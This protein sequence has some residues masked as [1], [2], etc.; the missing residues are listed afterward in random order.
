MIFHCSRNA[1]NGDLFR[2]ERNMGV[3]KS[4]KFL[5]GMN[6]SNFGKREKERILEAIKDYEKHILEC[7]KMYDECENMGKWLHERLDED[8]YSKL[9]TIYHRYGFYEKKIDTTRN[10]LFLWGTT[11]Y[12]SRL[13]AVEM[14]R[15]AIIND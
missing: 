4:I 8:T 1:K 15:V 14:L 6:G 11:E 9:I 7:K 13:K 3:I 10:S 5:L 2:Y 12:Y